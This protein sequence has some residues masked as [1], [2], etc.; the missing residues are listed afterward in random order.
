MFAGVLLLAM[1]S[2][3]EGP[4][5]PERLGAFVRGEIR[6]LAVTLNDRDIFGEYGF[7]TAHQ[8]DYTGSQGRRMG[9]EAFRFLDSEGAHAAFLYY[10]PA[11][12]VSPMIW[13]I[14]AITGGGVTV[15]EYRNYMLRFHGALPSISSSL[16]EMLSKLPGLAP[17]TSPWDL[18]GRYVDKLSMR[19][20]LGPISLQ[21]FPDRIPPSVAGF[22]SGAKGR[23]A[24]F[25]TPAGRVTAIAFKYP[26]EDVARERATA[27]A[28][29]PDAVVRV[30]R[31]CAA[32]VFG[33]LDSNV[34]DGPL[35]GYFCGGE[36]IVWDPHTMSDRGMS[37]GEGMSG[38]TFGGLIFGVVIAT[39]RRLDRLRDPFPNRMIFL[40]L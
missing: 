9:V 7:K 39:L 8:A 36:G 19:A 29:V 24:S 31:V 3:V 30:D 20:I 15:M 34:E 12:A 13:R 11:H 35:S 32:V 25:E 18:E 40:R 1:A 5:L 14:D 23:I 10:R 21:R 4:P 6:D 33:T 37:L 28:Q 38:V 2:A 16:E 17:D 26:T 22:R 27:L